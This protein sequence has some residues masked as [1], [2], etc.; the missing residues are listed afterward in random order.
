MQPLRRPRRLSPPKMRTFSPSTVCC[1]EKSLSLS[2]QSPSRHCRHQRASSNDRKSRLLQGAT[3]HPARPPR[4]RVDTQAPERGRAPPADFVLLWLEHQREG[5]AA[6]LRP[7]RATGSRTTGLAPTSTR[8][9]QSMDVDMEKP[10]TP[11]AAGE[12]QSVSR[13]QTSRARAA[14][15]PEVDLYI[16]LLVLL[17]LIDR[18]SLKSVRLALHP[19]VARMKSPRCSGVG[20]RQATDGQNQRAQPP[21]ARSSGRQVLLLL[22]AYLRTEQHARHHPTVRVTDEISPTLERSTPCSCV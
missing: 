17:H 1:P 9:F 20:L 7:S 6:R 18:N 13:P 22:R 10:S 8:M 4:T 19:L 16:H 15:L 12:K 21:H 2:G 3:L 5:N 11:A 14:A